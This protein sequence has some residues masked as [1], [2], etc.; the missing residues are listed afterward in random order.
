MLHKNLQ[1]LPLTFVKFIAEQRKEFGEKKRHQF[2]WAWNDLGVSP[3][4]VYFAYGLTGI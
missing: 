1:N 2:R 3:I 4:N